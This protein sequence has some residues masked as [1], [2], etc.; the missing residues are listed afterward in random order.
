[1]TIPFWCLFVA[2]LLPTVAA[3]AGSVARYRSPA[4]LDNHNP[5]QQVAQLEG[6]GARAYAAQAN[7]WEALALFTVAIFIN[8]A[9]QGDPA[10]SAALAVAFIGFR[11][12]HLLAYLGNLATLRSLFYAL[13]L[14]ACIGLVVLGALA[15]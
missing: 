15:A 3:V 5:R 14:F 13:A 11:V 10:W 1:M 6:F 12:G 7:A 9:A 4:G 2:M 8:H